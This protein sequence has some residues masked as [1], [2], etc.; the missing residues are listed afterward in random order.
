MLGIFSNIASKLALSNF[1]ILVDAFT[2]YKAFILFIAFKDLN[3][4]NP[5]R[6]KTLKYVANFSKVMIIFAFIFLIFNFLNLVNMTEAIRYG[7]KEY[8]F[9]FINAGTLGYYLI[10]ILPLIEETKNS[11]LYKLLVLILIFSTL[12]G[13]QLIFVALYIYF[14]FSGKRNK[15]LNFIQIMHQKAKA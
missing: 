9:I 3:E 13:P 5:Y 15:L 4:N 7:L 12:K 2:M 1:A 14:S 10:A 11:S 6:D 8:K